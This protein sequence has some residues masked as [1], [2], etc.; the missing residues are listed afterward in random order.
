MS[1]R[2]T[3]HS[4]ERRRRVLM[5]DSSAATE[6]VPA[7]GKRP[8]EGK[9]GKPRNYSDAALVAN[10]PPVTGLIPKRVW[11]L[12]VLLLSALTLIVLLNLLY[13]ELPRIANVVGAQV[14]AFDFEVRGNLA[15]WLSS[16][17]LAWGAVMS[18]QVYN[19]RRHRVD[20]Y[21]G[22]YRIW[23]W[24][25]V[26]LVGASIDAAA[27]VH[28]AIGGALQ[29]L[30]GQSSTLN[31]STCW[32]ALAAVIVG[33]VGLRIGIEVRR[34]AGTLTSLLLALSL[35]GVAVAVRAGWL[36]LA[37]ELAWHALVTATLLGHLCVWF[38]TLSYAQHVYL[39]AQGLLEEKRPK[40]A[41]AKRKTEDPAE[42]SADSN[43][44]KSA[45]TAPEKSV[46]GKQVRIDSAH[47]ESTQKPASTGGPL[48]A[49]MISSTA[50]KSPPANSDDAGGDRKLS[51]A[52]RKRLR[53]S[54][55]DSD[56]E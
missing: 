37:G 12:S 45:A 20:D 2:R 41:K 53:R 5:D 49:A 39:D 51:K 28:D 44:E 38:T 40:P 42:K 47:G 17:L 9:G 26:L 48:K 11:T 32:L 30:G 43:E 34:S 13:A 31:A 7:A 35:Y 4:D 21:K 14:N 50:A 29:T 27:G 8:R 23:I 16:A 46:A 36:P 33:G 24:L 6:T 55:R 22:R 56:D 1:L 10:Q 19:L 18:V 25:A 54:G 15:A 3:G 52:E